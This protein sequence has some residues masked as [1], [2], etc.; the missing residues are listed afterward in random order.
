MRVAR[1]DPG[2]AGNKD[3]EEVGSGGRQGQPGA[4]ELSAEDDGKSFC[5]AASEALDPAWL[6]PELGTVLR[7]SI[8][9]SRK[10]SVQVEG[11]QRRQS[12][13]LS[14]RPQ[15][16]GGYTPTVCQRAAASSKALSPVHH[17]T[18]SVR[19]APSVFV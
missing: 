11:G 14:C 4:A 10:R 12:L 16:D 13:G 6:L 8:W 19:A 17:V 2:G 9:T 3:Q 5:A 7:P 15:T 18:V 1:A